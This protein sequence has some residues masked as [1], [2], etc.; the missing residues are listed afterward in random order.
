MVKSLSGKSKTPEQCNTVLL[1]EDAMLKGDTKTIELNYKKMTKGTRGIS[2]HTLKELSGSNVVLPMSL[3]FIYQM[4]SKKDGVLCQRDFTCLVHRA[5][6]QARKVRKE[7]IKSRQ[8]YQCHQDKRRLTGS[9]YNGDPY[10][11]PLNRK[12]SRRIISAIKDVLQHPP[13]LKRRSSQYASPS[14]NGNS[15]TMATT[16]TLPAMPASAPSSSRPSPIFRTSKKN[17]R[18]RN[19][20]EGHPRN[21]FEGLPEGH[22][23]NPLEGHAVRFIR[24]HLVGY[25]WRAR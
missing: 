12:L 22:P 3:A 19:A 23:R 25:R 1:I 14:S 6:E 10:S 16:A 24:C 8:K 11:I 9:P 2:L 4:D 15:P 17:R 18:A 7:V 13:H 5:R 21:M 20:L